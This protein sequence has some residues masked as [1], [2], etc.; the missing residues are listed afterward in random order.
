M[1]PSFIGRQT[2]LKQLLEL[3]EK[4]TASFVVV[5]GRRRIGKSRLIQE[6]GKYFEQ[7]YS[8]IGLP[9]ERHTT[10]SYQLNE[11]SRQVAR[12]FNTSFARYDD[13][14]DLLWAVGER[15]LSGKTLL[16][17]DE[18]SWMGSKDPT[19]LGKIKNFWDTQLKNNNKLIFVICGSASSWIEKNI[20]SSTGFVGRIS[21]TLTLG[22]LSLSDCNEFWPKNIS[23][24]EKFKV[25]AVTGGIPKY[26]EEVNF[27]HSAEENIKR[28]CFTKGGF[29]VEEFNQIFSDLFM[30]KTAF[31]K[32]IVRALSTGAKEQ[33]EICA[34]L[35]IVRHG[36]ISEYLYELELAG[37][38]A[39]DHTWS[40][41]TGT[42]SRLRRYRLQDNYL[43]F[44][45]KYIE[46]DL[47]KIGRDTYSIG[48]LPEW[49]TIIGLQFENLVLNNRK[50]I[51]NILGVDGIISENPFFQKRT[52]NSAGCQIDYMIQTKFNTLYICEI[53][54]SKDKIG[55][56][57]IQEVQK[58]IDALNRPKGFSC[59]P[60]LIHVNDVS[61]DVIDS[62][63]F[64]HIID[65]GKL[66]N[67]K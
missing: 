27:K 40:I 38:I 55:H 36:R 47:G 14:S 63:Y 15:L 9:P 37:F 20:L 62:G 19:F 8:F 46:K 49:Y 11:F 48:F 58:K 50:N 34:T 3:T 35:N 12:Q 17:F 22:E 53:K 39:K 64:S 54:F 13:W 2:E 56:S 23:A 66:L 33:E 59:R 10:T 61:D 28:L 5:K 67:C 18:I 30:R 16:L 31:Y 44:Y 41:K 4:N 52:R 7:Y 25:L 26:L 1:S 60:V 65:F 6:F 45:L 42:D 21:L 24:Y 57:I 32:Q 51:H 43:R 29:L